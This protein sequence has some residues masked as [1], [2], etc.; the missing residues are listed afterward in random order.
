MFIIGVVAVYALVMS[1]YLWFAVRSA[2]EHTKTENDAF[3][4]MIRF[5]KIQKHENIKQLLQQT[6]QEL[7]REYQ[8]ATLGNAI[9]PLMLEYFERRLNITV[10]E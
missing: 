4:L 3:V 5:R 1:V 2:Y 9:N 6:P 10:H 7:V 8:K